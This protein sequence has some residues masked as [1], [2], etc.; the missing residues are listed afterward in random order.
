MIDQ[1]RKI[2]DAYMNIVVPNNAGEV[3]IRETKLAF[4]A[5]AYGAIKTIIS[6]AGRTE[7]TEQDITR[8]TTEFQSWL[9]KEADDVNTGRD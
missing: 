3:Q 6:S 1:F 8:M 7:L 5:G 9:T 2:L 4:L